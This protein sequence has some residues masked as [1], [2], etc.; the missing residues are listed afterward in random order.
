MYFTTRLSQFTLGDSYTPRDIQHTA[1]DEGLLGK[2]AG[3]A[4]AKYK[5]VALHTKF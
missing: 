1:W 5:I 3:V 2:A 4:Q